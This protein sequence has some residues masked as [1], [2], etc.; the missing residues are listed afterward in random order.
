MKKVLVFGTGVS[1]IGAV[2]L[3]E[4]LGC[5]IAIYDESG[6]V[7]SDI[8]HENRSGQSYEQV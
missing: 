8:E 7:I 6:K 2:K 5:R 3:L 4:K 1:G